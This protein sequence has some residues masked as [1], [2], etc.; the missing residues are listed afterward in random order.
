MK[1]DIIARLRSKLGI[2]ELARVVTNENFQF[3]I[4][5]V[6]EAEVFTVQELADRLLVSRS[7][8][9]R[10]AKGVKNSPGPELRISIINWIR[11]ELDKKFPEN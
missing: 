1:S 9:C 10:W 7:T 4:S 5:G 2:E 11:A 3:V 8:I 6:I